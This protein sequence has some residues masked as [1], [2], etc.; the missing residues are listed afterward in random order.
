MNS[1]LEVIDA[2]VDGEEVDARALKTALASEAGRDYFVD[3]WL[4]RDALGSDVPA[5]TMGT[6]SRPVVRS[7]RPWLIAAAICASVLGGYSLGNLNRTPPAASTPAV[8][9]IVDVGTPAAFPVPAPT[10]VIQLEFYN[11][12]AVSGGD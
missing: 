2:F 12:P 8:N 1:E 6:S 7:G 4:L 10:R 3:T 9:A 5:A 11:S